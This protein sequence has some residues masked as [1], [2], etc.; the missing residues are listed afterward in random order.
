MPPHCEEVL[1][2]YLYPYRVHL[3]RREDS[4]KY[5]ASL[6]TRCTRYSSLVQKGNVKVTG[7]VRIANESSYVAILTLPVVGFY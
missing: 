6:L 3:V 1:A 4:C 2:I 7:G 5:R